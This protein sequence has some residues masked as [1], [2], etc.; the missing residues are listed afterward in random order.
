M[1]TEK[2]K[3]AAGSAGQGLN[4]WWR[5]KGSKQVF[6]E[7]LDFHNHSKRQNRCTTDDLYTYVQN[8]SVRGVSPFLVINVFH[9]VLHGPYSRSNSNCFSSGPS[10]PVFLRKPIGT[11]VIIQGWGS[12]SPAPPPPPCGSAH[13][14]H[15]SD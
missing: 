8:H 15:S 5:L 6:Y 14:I 10:E 13:T 7:S 3:S 12:G 9:G 1:F 2:Y 11:F 4:F